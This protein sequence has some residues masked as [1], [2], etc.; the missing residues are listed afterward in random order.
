MILSNPNEYIIRLYEW[1][2]Y[3]LESHREPSNP[4][5]HWHKKE[6]IPSTHV[7]PFK[8]GSAAHSSISRNAQSHDHYISVSTEQF[9]NILKFMHAYITGLIS[10][11][12]KVCLKKLVRHSKRLR[13]AL[14]QN[15]RIIDFNH[16]Y[17]TVRPRK[18]WNRELSMFYL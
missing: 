10:D 11:Y 14:G 16:V 13:Y 15:Y 12:P 2:M 1:T 5:V 8:H 17:Y 6:L 7:P 9:L 18:K 4:L 3:I